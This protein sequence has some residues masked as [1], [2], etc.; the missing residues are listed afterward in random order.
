M[1]IELLYVPECANVASARALLHASIE[2]LGVNAPIEEREG[3][4]PSPSILVDGVDVM[5][6][7]ASIEAACRLDT[8]TRERVL[9]ALRS[10]A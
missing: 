1:K 7:P 4:Y 6:R 9:S 5:G 10:S 3:A 2:E 8:P